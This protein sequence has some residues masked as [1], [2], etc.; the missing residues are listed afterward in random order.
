MTGRPPLP[1]GTHGKIITKD[2][3]KAGDKGKTWRAH[4]YF[5]DADGKTRPVERRGKT[6]T[7]AENALQAALSER[8]RDAG[9][10][11]NGDSRVRTAAALWFEQR[12]TERRSIRAMSY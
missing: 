5:R 11:L 8:R 12:E 1:I 9:E 2:V 4:C 7:A 6:K 10:Q 3:T